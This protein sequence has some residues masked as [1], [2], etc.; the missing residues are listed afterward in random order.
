MRLPPRVAPH[1]LLL[2]A[3]SDDKWSRAPRR[4]LNWAESSFPKGKV[5]LGYWPGGYVFTTEMREAA[6]RFP[7]EHRRAAPSRN[8]LQTGPTSIPCHMSTGSVAEFGLS[9]S[10]FSKTFDEYMDGSENRGKRLFTWNELSPERLGA[11]IARHLPLLH[12]YGRIGMNDYVSDLPGRSRAEA[13]IQSA[14]DALTFGS[15]SCQSSSSGLLAGAKLR[16]ASRSAR[17][18][19]AP[20][21]HWAAR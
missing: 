20:S 9:P 12:P 18:F 4:Y 19:F 15:L 10:Y 11:E 6:Y 1:A 7:D 21:P 3:T 5:K 13:L 17:A 14:C 16:M 2:Q 8:H